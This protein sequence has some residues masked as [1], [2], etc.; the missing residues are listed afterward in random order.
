MASSIQNDLLRERISAVILKSLTSGDKEMQE[1]LKEIELRSSGQFKLKSPTLNSSLKKLEEQNFITT[2]IDE[3]KI[4]KR[5]KERKMFSLTEKGKDSFIKSMTEWE[6]QRS[7]ADQLLS[8]RP[9]NL[10]I[11][12]PVSKAPPKQRKPK[13]LLKE[14]NFV[15]CGQTV[16]SLTMDNASQNDTYLSF[17]RD[18]LDEQSTVS[19]SAGMQSDF[20]ENLQ[21]DL[22]SFLPPIDQESA[23]SNNPSMQ[24]ST[25]I[26]QMFSQ[27]SNNRSFGTY[28]DSLQDNSSNNSSVDTL[29]FEMSKSKTDN[30]EDSALNSTSDSIFQDTQSEQQAIKEEYSTVYVKPQFSTQSTQS[31]KVTVIKPF[32]ETKLFLERE[33]RR[34]LAELITDHQPFTSSQNEQMFPQNNTDTAQFLEQP[35]KTTISQDYNTPINHTTYVINGQEKSNIEQKVEVE[36][37]TAFDSTTFDLGNQK[38][39]EMTK[40]VATKNIRLSN[41]DENYQQN[42]NH[43]DALYFN[44][45]NII[46]SKQNVHEL[47]MRSHNQTVVKEYNAQNYY[48]SNKLMSKQF[49]IL[50]SILF[51]EIALTFIFFNLLPTLSTPVPYWNFLVALVVAAAFPL[52]SSFTN[53]TNPEKRT[54]YTGSFGLSLKI[55][56]IIFTQL[57]AIA[58]LVMLWSNQSMNWQE[59][60]LHSIPSM[61]FLSNIVVS[62]IIF[63]KLYSSR[64]YA[65]D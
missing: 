17:Y 48:R 22:E 60:L 30:F 44:S 31:D 10:S 35:I 3:G 54:R 46:S 45:N 40:Q 52:Y 5:I 42:L 33:Y 32:D 47:S 28:L 57:S 43:L 29:Y 55:R 2:Y 12:P 64:M 50:F 20:V 63:N 56:S 65:I 36:N 21:S 19:Q 14:Q 25:D 51:T 49:N 58:W 59:A 34:L 27:L 4:G 18:E 23:V 13:L 8:D 38:Q 26:Q 16:D 62:C 15:D 53:Y 39:G 9:F 37:S 7:V 11:L 24:C 1:I 61:I 6:Y 41:F